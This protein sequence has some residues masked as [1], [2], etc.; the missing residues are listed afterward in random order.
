MEDGSIEVIG[1]PSYTPTVSEFTM[2]TARLIGFQAKF[3]TSIPSPNIVW[4]GQL[5]IIMD[6]VTGCEA[7][8]FTSPNPFNDMTIDVYTGSMVSQT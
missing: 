4:I 8:L 5:G 7:A 2:L 1:T 3:F 6:T